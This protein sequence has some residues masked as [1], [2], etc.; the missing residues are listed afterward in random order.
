M[1]LTPPKLSY[2]IL[3]LDDMLNRAAQVCIPVCFEHIFCEER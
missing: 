2:P 1:S 3:R